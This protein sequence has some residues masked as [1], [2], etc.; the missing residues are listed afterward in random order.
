MMKTIYIYFAVLTTLFFGG[1][2]DTTET[3]IVKEISYIQINQSTQTSLYATT[4]ELNITATAYFNDGSSA[5]VTTAVQWSVPDYNL[6]AIMGGTLYAVSNGDGNSG[7]AFVNE[8]SIS[9]RDLNDT[10]RTSIEVIPLTSIDIIE[11]ANITDP[12]NVDPTLTYVFEANATYGDSSSQ[13]IAPGNLKNIEWVVEGNATLEVIDGA[14]H[15][16]FESGETN[17]T[18]YAFD[19]NETNATR[20]YIAP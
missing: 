19:I 18:I 14:A 13:L 17:V 6:T 3:P 16:Q 4:D 8:V 9:Y 7:S 1:C 12:N 11:D 20:T 5:D 15:I 2:G 10:L